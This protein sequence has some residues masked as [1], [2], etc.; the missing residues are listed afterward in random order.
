MPD[1]TPLAT[2]PQAILPRFPEA[3]NIASQE[4]VNQQMAQ[5]MPMSGSNFRLNQTTNAFEV[6]NLTTG[7]HNA[8]NTEGA[9]GAESLVIQPQD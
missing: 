9:S 4:Y 2:S 8:L 5:C 1:Y 3:P 6:T 7:L